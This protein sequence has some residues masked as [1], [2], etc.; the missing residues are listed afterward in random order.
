MNSEIMK[1]QKSLS[2]SA[3]T[4]FLFSSL[5]LVLLLLL[6]GTVLISINK[7]VIP[8]T[9]KSAAD[10]GSARG[11]E[12]GRWFAGHIQELNRYASQA[13]L[14]NPESSPEDISSF[15][16]SQ[17]ASLH[18]E[19]NDIFFAYPDGTAIGADGIRVDKINSQDYYMGIFRAAQDYAIGAPSRENPSETPNIIIAH[20]VRDPEGRVLGLIAE[21]I[22]STVLQDTIN[23]ISI[24]P[25]SIALVTDA[26]ANVAAHPDSSK[27]INFNLRHSDDQGYS[28]LEDIGTLMTRSKSGIAQFSDPDRAIQYAIY[29]PIP[30]TFGWSLAIIAPEA[31]LLRQ[32]NLLII[33]IVTSIIAAAI[34]TAIAA[35]RL[36]KSI[37]KPVREA[38]LELH[39]ISTH[40]G[41]LTKELAILRN[42][43]TGTLATAF[44]TFIGTLARLIRGLRQNMGEAENSTIS[45]A[46][47]IEETAAATNEITAN[48]HSAQNHYDKV[49]ELILNNN[50]R[51]S[52]A[53]AL[54]HELEDHGSSQASAVDQTSASITQMNASLQNIA[55]TLDR[56][57]N[58]TKELQVSLNQTQD[59]IHDIAEK[60]DRIAGSADQMMNA[61]EIIDEISKQTNLLSMN[62]AIEAAHAG[63]AGKGFAVVAEEI[64]VL[65]ASSSE[66][67]QTIASELN[68]TVGIIEELTRQFH[69]SMQTFDK[70]SRASEQT[71]NSFDEIMHVIH[72]LA[73]GAHEINRAVS[74]LQTISSETGDKIKK[75]DEDLVSISGSNQDIV[76]M[77]KSFSGSLIEITVGTREINESMNEMQE[78]MSIMSEIIRQIL[79]DFSQFQT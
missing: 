49:S 38:A 16:Q 77:S 40:G 30:G 57:Q 73:Q 2:I 63:E 46:S 21:S 10:I 43:E 65:A 8:L 69:D 9:E 71:V 37:A 59:N 75:L 12:L 47:G 33:A 52:E 54:I 20:D 27:I 34:I 18:S 61:V 26:S 35:F 4:T 15:L 42:D 44:N 60:I 64:R 17:Q 7:I 3:R 28:G 23:T 1:T 58:E 70:L 72:E 51:I 48:I 32:V 53:T 31:E 68:A 13:V 76:N 5:V 22:S 56:R 39:E 74:S 36:S 55:G 6:G 62:A 50:V 66:S 45:I 14:T 78:R 24:T 29:S 41:D 25:S 19:A 67:S 79:Q 11:S